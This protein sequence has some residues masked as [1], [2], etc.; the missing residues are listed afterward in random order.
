MEAYAGLCGQLFLPIITQPAGHSRLPHPT[1]A[2]LTNV[3]L[4]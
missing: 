4:P 1:D 2:E 3:S